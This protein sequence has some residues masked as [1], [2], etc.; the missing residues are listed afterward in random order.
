MNWRC[1]VIL[2][3][4]TWSASPALAGD[5]HNLQRFMS[6][7]ESVI[8][9]VIQELKTGDKQTHWMWFVFPQIQGLGRSEIAKHYGISSTE[10]AL[11]Y[12]SHPVL[13]TRLKQCVG[14][15]A[16]L[17]DRSAE[18]V[19]GSTDAMKFRSSMSLFALV[20]S[21]EN[22]FEEVLRKY[23]DGSPDQKTLDILHRD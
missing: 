12:L 14:I 5:P 7:Q 15:L 3:H 19:F 9:I 23:Y 4:S 1:G 17:S 21:G 16:D 20:S 2:A 6:A 13:G 8:D 18:Q 22:I 10:E 11:A